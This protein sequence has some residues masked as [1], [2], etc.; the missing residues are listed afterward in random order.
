MLVQENVS[1]LS[2]LPRSATHLTLRGG[3]FRTLAGLPPALTTL[4]IAS[5]DSL[6]D[7]SALAELVAVRELKLASCPAVSALCLPPH[8]ER[9]SATRLDALTDVTGASDVKDLALRRCASLTRVPDL[10]CPA[11]ET[12]DL[13]NCRALVDLS[14]VASLPSLG[15]LTLV[16][17][18]AVS[19]LSP[20]VDAGD[21]VVTLHDT[22]VER[23]GLEKRLKWRCVFDASPPRAVRRTAPWFTAETLTPG[24]RKALAKIKPLM[25][26]HLQQAVALIDASDPGLA[27]LLV[28]GTHYGSVFERKEWRLK[29]VLYHRRWSERFLTSLFAVTHPE[30][31]RFAASITT[32][33]GRIMCARGLARLPHLETLR[34]SRGLI[35]GPLRSTSLRALE[36][37]Y[38]PTDFTFLASELRERLT[39]LQIDQGELDAKT[40]LALPNLE[41]LALHGRVT[42]PEAIR[43]LPKLVTIT[44]NRGLER[45]GL[46]DLAS[47]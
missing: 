23:T 34:I 45:L 8:A 35:H 26:T 4:V 31:D 12:L 32:L 40:L 37:R 10:K 24:R 43:A 41:T 22:A 1:D 38:A 14:A 16:G 11:L 9:V 47:T 7:T 20:L 42:N 36:L 13:G 28:D 33:H 3:S 5:V 18:R 17:C 46:E 21:C 29:P 25:Q 6:C 44:S 39:L 27:A 19:D 15:L 30:L 2:A